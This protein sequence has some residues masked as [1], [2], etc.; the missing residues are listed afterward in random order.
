MAAYNNITVK[1]FGKLNLVLEIVGKQA[2]GY[3]VLNSVMQSVS[4]YD[5][6]EISLKKGSG[7]E[8]TCENGKND[9]PCNENNLIWKACTEFKNFTNVDFGGKLCINVQKNLPSMAGM[10]GGSAD[11]GAMLRCLNIMYNTLLDDEDLRKIGAKLGAD[12]PFCMTGGTRLCQGVGEK[13]HKLPSPECYFVIIKPDVSISTPEAYKRYDLI[14]NP[15][16]HSIDTFL[17]SLASGNIYSTCLNMNNVLELALY[18]E[19]EEIEKAKKLLMEQGALTALM[20]GSGSAVFGV[21]KDEKSAE[22]ALKKIRFSKEYGYAE[23][24]SPV[25]SGYEIISRY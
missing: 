16:R 12:V 5:L 14:E 11:C 7:I 6:L 17:K 22:Y 2:D 18:D 1:A 19:K 15:P 4:C 13:V 10:G 9:F 20:T 24:C 21:F 8:I 3:H 23:M 25:K